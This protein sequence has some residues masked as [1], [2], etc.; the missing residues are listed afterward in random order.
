MN[1]TWP[2]GRPRSTNNA[3]SILY[4]PRAVPDSKKRT[5]PKAKVLRDNTGHHLCTPI[6]SQADADKQ[7]RIKGRV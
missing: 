6:A 5:G 3:F 1:A 4:E 2:D 7:A